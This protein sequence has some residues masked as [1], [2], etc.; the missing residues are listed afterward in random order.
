M[1]GL[2][3][4][5]SMILLLQSFSSVL[6]EFGVSA[7]RAKQAAICAAEGIMIVGFVWVLSLPPILELYFSL[8]QFSSLNLGKPLLPSFRL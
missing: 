5:E 3:T 2:V 6:E 4:H 1:A 8:E 7:G